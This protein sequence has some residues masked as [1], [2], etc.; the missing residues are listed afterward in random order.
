[1]DDSDRTK[2]VKRSVHSKRCEKPVLVV[3]AAHPVFAM[4]NRSSAFSEEHE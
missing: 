2:W 4:V 3:V 1:M